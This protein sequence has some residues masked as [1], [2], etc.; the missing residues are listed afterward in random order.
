MRLIVSSTVSSSSAAPPAAS[1]RLSAAA[2]LPLWLEC[3]R[4]PPV[5]VDAADVVE[6]VGEFLDRA[7]DDL[8]AG[9]DEPAEVAGMIGVR[10][11]RAHLRELPDGVTNLL[12]EVGPVRYHDNGVEGRR[13]IAGDA[14]E[15]VSEPSD[16]VRLAAAGRML[17]EIPFSRAVLSGA[18]EQPPH[19]VKLVIAREH[20]FALQ[21][22]RLRVLA[23]NDLGIV[24]EDVGQPQRRED[25][26]PQVVRLEAGRIRRISRAVGRVNGARW[27]CRAAKS[28]GVAL[29][30]RRTTSPCL[31]HVSCLYE[32]P[33]RRARR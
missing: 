30:W 3:A 8:L 24:F 2:L 25:A 27:P 23:F 15:L 21:L 4:E 33:H 31:C 19:H 6:N 26:S 1:A 14:D 17:D 29:K 11:G 9:F 12:I 16:R 20:L 32:H 18:G 10:D 22:A 13:A 5:P 28:P 7:D